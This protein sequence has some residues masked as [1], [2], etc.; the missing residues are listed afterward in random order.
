[1]IKSFVAAGLGVSLIS[2][3]SRVIRCAG[4]VKLIALKERVVAGTGLA[5]RRD[6]APTQAAKTFITTVRQRLRPRGEIF[7]VANLD[8]QLD[9]AMQ[10][11][12]IE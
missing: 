12:I 2:A 10:A 11:G 3:S 1:M 6:H 7:W 9:S 8:F 5:Y 4:R